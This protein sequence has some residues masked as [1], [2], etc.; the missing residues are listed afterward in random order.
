[1]ENLLHYGADE[2]RFAQA[3]QFPQLHLARV[4]S[5]SRELY[6]VVTEEGFLLAEV[7]GR[8]RFEA[9]RPADFPAVGDFVLCDRAGDEEGNAVIHQL[10]PRKT[11]FTRRSAGEGEE[12]QV[13]AANIDLV[14]LCMSLN[15]NYNLSRLERYLSVAWSSGARPVVLLTKADLCSDWDRVRRE[16]E[17]VALGVDIFPV[18]QGDAASWTP[19]RALLTEGVSASFLGSSGVGKSTLINCLLGEERLATA[20]IGGG[21]KGRHTS[22]RRELL[23]LPDGGV[24]IDTP[25]MRELGAESTDLQSSFADIEALA[26]DCRFR[27][28]KHQGEPGCAVAQA[29]EQGELSPRRLENFLKLQRE[30]KYDGLNSRQIE[31]EKLNA[32][33]AGIG[34]MKKFKDFVKEKNRHRS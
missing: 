9:A 20:Q 19:V 16:V 4:V 13:V 28:C 6:R 11:L 8:F 22:T 21:G 7:S 26:E 27:D 10:L 14:F 3:S 30:T 1:M 25:G 29:I 33:F 18:S 34:G 2:S 12:S 17:G 31:T 23:A 32:M 15:E 24:V 5:Q